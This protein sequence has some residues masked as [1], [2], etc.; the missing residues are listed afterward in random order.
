MQ[1]KLAVLIHNR[2]SRVA[3]ALVADYHI[4]I[5]GQQVHHAALAFVA[6]VDADNRTILHDEFSPYRWVSKRFM[7]SA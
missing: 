6:P 1:G 2:V 5:L 7:I 3:A 4:K